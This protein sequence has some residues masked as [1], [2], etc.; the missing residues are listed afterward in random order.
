M[1]KIAGFLVMAFASLVAGTASSTMWTSH[2]ST[3]STAGDE[4]TITVDGVSVLVRAYSTKTLNSQAGNFR[5]GATVVPFPNY[6]GF[7]ID[8]MY[9]SVD[10][11]ENTFPEWGVDNKEIYDLLVF[12]L[13]ND[14]MKLE[15]LALGWA[16][17]G[18]D[19]SVFVGG[20]GLGA[21]YNFSNTCFTGCTTA[22]TSSLS[23]LGFSQVNLD[24][25]AVNTAITEGL[26]SNTGRYVAISGSLVTSPGND[27]FK[28]NMISAGSSVPTPG[29][30]ALLGLALV[31]MGSLRRR[32]PVAA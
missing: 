20:N 28:V 12:E 24:N 15:S 7:G 2:S 17:P 26:N 23:A 10:T 32:Q 16:E 22:G 9:T 27:K 18:S 3:L 19:I 29:T 4:Y 5:S 30:L 21:G 1:K 25:V 31:G 6:E 13:P 11:N 8:N 14:G